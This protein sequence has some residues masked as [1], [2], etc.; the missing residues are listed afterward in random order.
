DRYVPTLL[1]SL[2]SQKVVHICCGEDHT[3]ALTKEGGV[4]TFG[5]GGYGQLGHNSTSHEINPRKVFELMGSVVTQITC[6]RQHT[7]AFVPSSGRI[8]SFGLGGNGQLGTGTTSNRKS[9]FTVKGNWI[10]YSTQCPM[11][12][13]TEERYCVKRIFSGGDQSF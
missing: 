1:K 4:F 9:P 12:T 6:G 11:T 7:T 5:A 8:Y 13:D 10:P 2:R 3:A